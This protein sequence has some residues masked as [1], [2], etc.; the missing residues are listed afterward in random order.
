MTVSFEWDSEHV[1]RLLQVLKPYIQ[2]GYLTVLTSSPLRGVAKL[3]KR[4]LTPI[5][6][7]EISNNICLYLS[8]GATEYVGLWDISL[9]LQLYSP[10]TGIGSVLQVIKGVDDS[11]TKH[12]I[13]RRSDHFLPLVDDTRVAGYIAQTEVITELHLESSSVGVVPIYSS[14]VCDKNSCNATADWN[15]RANASTHLWKSLILNGA[16]NPR[17]AHLRRWGT[18]E[19]NNYTEAQNRSIVDVDVL[20]KAKGH[21]LLFVLPSRSKNAPVQFVGW[22]SYDQVFREVDGNLDK[23]KS[24]KIEHFTERSLRNYSELPVMASDLSDLFLGAILERD[25]DSDQLQLTTFMLCHAIVN[26][27]I[28]NLGARNVKTD[29]IPTWQRALSRWDEQKYRDSGDRA[30]DPQHI[31]RVSNGPGLPTYEVLGMFVPNSVTRDANVNR[32][33]DILRCPMMGTGEEY[34]ELIRRGENVSVEVLRGAESLVNFTVP[35]RSRKTG[36]M[37]SH[38]PEASRLDVWRGYGIDARSAAGFENDKIYM[39]VPGMESNP[40]VKILPLFLEFVQHHLLLGVDHM[41]MA[42]NFAW[43]SPHMDRLLQIY[44]SYIDEGKLTM[45]SQAGDGVDFMATFGG[46]HWNRNVLKVTHINMCLYLAKGMSDYIGVWDLDEF[47]IPKLPYTNIREVLKAVETKSWSGEY[48]GKNASVSSGDGYADG[49]D[50]PFCYLSLSSQVVL[51]SSNYLDPDRPWLGQRFPHGPEGFDAKMTRKMGFKKSIL[52]TRRIFQAGLHISGACKLEPK[53]T[54]CGVAN[55]TGGQLMNG[56]CYRP[57]SLKMLRSGKHSEHYFD[58]VLDD[59]DFLSIDPVR[60]AVV[61]HFYSTHRSH[62]VLAMRPVSQE[63]LNS[64]SEYLAR[65]FN[66]VMEELQYRDLV[67]YVGLPYTRAEEMY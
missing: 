21:D 31:C 18:L 43:D 7:K 27:T 39:C 38:R 41:F 56:F 63:A 62:Y 20:L 44:R 67:K 25:F 35:W 48:E 33:I 2:S 17:V 47:F 65:F 52:P 14:K 58:E 49:E 3:L 57:S 26:N 13:R 4:T 8:K 36:L 37:L 64:R 16:V 9:F 53:W 30:F 1:K 5:M 54:A 24:L 46:I 66:P 10:F 42:A 19:R 61:Y 45:A 15:Q 11:D 60:I 23:F 6:E 28:T 59:G 51:K 32:R 34:L 29:M 50:H 40:S 12:I 22:T 55:S